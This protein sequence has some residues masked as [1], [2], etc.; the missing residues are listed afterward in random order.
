MFA[1]RGP[2]FILAS[3]DMAGPFL[4][5]QLRTTRL[6]IGLEECVVCQQRLPACAPDRMQ[7]RWRSSVSKFMHWLNCKPNRSTAFRTF[8]WVVVLV[9]GLVHGVDASLYELTFNDGQGNSGSGQFDVEQTNNNYYASSGYLTVNSGGA[10][11]NWTLYTAGAYT[12]YPGYLTSPSGAYI[13]N[14]AVYPNGNPQY[15]T[16]NPLLDFYGLLFTQTNG[17]ELNLWGNA[18][19]T[20]T[21]GGN[22]NGWQNF[23]V[24]ITFG[25]T[26]ITPVGPSL[27]ATNVTLSRYPTT[28]VKARISTLLAND[29][30]SDGDPISLVSISAT[31]A[32]SGA[33]ATNSG[34]VLYTP[35][36]GYTNTDSF[37]YVIM[38][39]SLQATGAVAVAIVND[40]NAA[41]NIE[42]SLTVGNGS[43]VTSF[44]G[45]PGRTYSIQFTTNLTN[46]DWQ[47]VGTA[48]ANATGWF[49]YTDSPG[50]GALARFYR[51]TYP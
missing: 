49:Q 27:I 35:P 18:D 11:G 23:N 2:V 37:S 51:S 13:Y 29:F 32:Q 14:N 46:P 6:A 34:W 41:Q 42:S 22:I 26:I 31:S 50:T 25:G 4:V 21:L 47:T 24:V 9:S 15:P 30:D 44:F 7:P 39:A 48:A 5:G 12:T 45:I 10:A 43:F 16:G 33:V 28:G 3:R 1:T 17:N 36:A 8:L 20:Y 40:T 19:G 38:D